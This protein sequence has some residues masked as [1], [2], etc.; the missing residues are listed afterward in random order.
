MESNYSKLT[1]Y[2][3]ADLLIQ[4]QLS[5]ARAGCMRYSNF[6]NGLLNKADT[7][8]EPYKDFHDLS[9]NS[10]MVPSNFTNSKR[11]NPGKGSIGSSLKKKV[12][13]YLPAATKKL[14][15]RNCRKFN[16]SVSSMVELSLSI[17]H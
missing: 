4:V 5:A 10:S 6:V 13:F 16:L 17:A 15:K 7:M 9:I 8:T 12:T 11:G 3:P 2:I 1:V 14:I